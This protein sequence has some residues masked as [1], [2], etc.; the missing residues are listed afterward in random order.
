[1]TE[2]NTKLLIIPL[3]GLICVNHLGADPVVS[4][5][6]AKLPLKSKCVLTENPII[7]HHILEQKKP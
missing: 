6:H 3:G 2:W 5:T 4:I 7:M 1:M